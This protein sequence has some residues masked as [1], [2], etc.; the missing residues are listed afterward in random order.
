MRY[1]H[2]RSPNT[3]PLDFEPRRARARRKPPAAVR[4]ATAIR[5]RGH[6][7]NS[8]VSEVQLGTWLIQGTIILSMLAIVAF[9]HV[10]LMTVLGAWF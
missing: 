1:F 3:L 7:A 10:P 5:N 2:L 6:L 4:R 8:G 9:F